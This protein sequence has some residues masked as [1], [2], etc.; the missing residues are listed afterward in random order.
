MPR[1]DTPSKV[2]GT[3]VYAIDVRLPGMVYAT[4]LH[5]PVHTGEPESWNDAD[6]KK[7]PGVIGTVRLPNGV[8]IVAEHFEQAM[9]ARNAL[10]AK[11]KEGAGGGLRLRARARG[12]RQGPPRPEGAD[13]EPRRRRATSRRPSPAR[14]RRYKAEFRSDYGYH[15]Q[16][17]PLNAVV[18]INDAGDRGRGLGRHARRRTPP[19]TRW[20]RRSASSPTRSRCTSAT[21]AAASA[22]ARSATTP[23]S[24]RAS[25]RRCAAR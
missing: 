20:R 3:A 14:P 8:A 10:K 17:E 15:A 18:R 21:W 9:A 1:R 19:A 7:M 16:M 23:P 5:S 24:A 4:A 22:G 25:P 2:N 12:L 11:W 6:I 13:H